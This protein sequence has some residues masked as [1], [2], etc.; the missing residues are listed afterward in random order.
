MQITHQSGRLTSPSHP[1]RWRRR[2]RVRL[3]IGDTV[4]ISVAM[5]VAVI[6]RFG[7]P[8]NETVQGFLGIPYTWTAV[9]LA[10]LWLLCLHAAQAYNLRSLFVGSGEYRTIARATLTMFGC[11]SIFATLTRLQLARGFL[12]VAF[13][14][15]LLLLLVGRVAQRRLLIRSRVAGRF[16]EQVLVIGAP[17]EVRHVV[18]SIRQLPV[19]GYDVV[20]VTT[21]DDAPSFELADG[22]I[23]DQTG[24]L[25]EAAEAAASLGVTTVIVAGQSLAGPAFLRRLGWRLEETG[26]ELVLASRM[27]DIAGPRIHWHPMEGLPL[28]SVEMPRYSGMKYVTK[29]AFDL[30]VGLSLTLLA[31]PMMLVVAVLIK[32]GDGGPVFYRQERV[33][34]NGRRFSM[35]KF[36][37]MVPD[38]DRH[39]GELSATNEGNA[40]LFKL[41]DDPRITRVGTVIRRYSIDELPQLFEVLRGN[42]S[43]VGPRPPLPREVESYDQH[44]HRRLYV[45]PGMTGPWQVGGRS[46]LT[47]DESVRK[48]LYYVENWSMTGDLLIML[49]TVKAVIRK[50]GAY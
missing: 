23:V 15:G 43:L 7:D 24:D 41:H 14:L 18:E 48:D 47:W 22:T 31:A 17:V 19:A 44:V 39:V 20:A 16:T 2:L 11:V 28:I 29:R 8:N 9:G 3:L 36:R 49:K 12:A 32:F 40:V 13:P 50:D 26:C 46:N 1:V 6:T 37:S 38:A 4:G 42:M 45:K 21:G 34:M 25:D 30:A 10:V 5:I 33:G 27:T 35:T